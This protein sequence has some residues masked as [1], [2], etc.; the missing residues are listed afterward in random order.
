MVSRQFGCYL[1]SIKFLQGVNALCWTFALRWL[2]LPT[3][4]FVFAGPSRSLQNHWSPWRPVAVRARRPQAVPH[5]HP[6]EEGPGR[7]QLRHSGRSGADPPSGW[8]CQIMYDNALCP[9]VVFTQS[10]VFDQVQ[11]TLGTFS[12]HFLSN[13]LRF[14]YFSSYWPQLF[15]L[16]GKKKSFTYTEPFEFRMY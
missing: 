13:I 3:H 10:R 2:V 11:S 7:A 8:W 12:L 15:K 6:C 14:L 4:I 16:K 1:Q 5:R 9:L